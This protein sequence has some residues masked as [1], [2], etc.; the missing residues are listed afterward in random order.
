MIPVQCFL[1]VIGGQANFCWKSQIANPQ[2]LV[3]IPLSQIRNFLRYAS[4]QI[5]N[6]QIFMIIPQIANPQI[7]TK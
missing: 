7:S 1:L 6:P 3:L 5:A 4:P 2:I